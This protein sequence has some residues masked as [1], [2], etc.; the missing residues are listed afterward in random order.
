MIALLKCGAGYGFFDKKEDI[1]DRIENYETAKEV[2]KRTLKLSKLDA[3]Y[4][5]G[6]VQQTIDWLE[7]YN[8]KN[9]RSWQQQPWLKGSLGIL[10]EPAGDEETGEFYLGDAVLSYDCNIGLQVRKQKDV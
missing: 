10:F 1:S 2:A 3:D 6:S 7:N 5:F 9:L 4:A 8:Q